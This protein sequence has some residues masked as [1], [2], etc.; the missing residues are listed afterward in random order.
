[1]LKNKRKIQSHKLNS[2]IAILS[3]L[4]IF[5]ITGIWA[6]LKDEEEASNVFTIGEVDIELIEKVSGTAGGNDEV[7]YNTVLESVTGTDGT[8]NTVTVDAFTEIEP[9]Q[10]IAKQPYVKNTGKNN[11]YVYMRVSV[12]L[13]EIAGTDTELFSYTTNSGW[14]LAGTSEEEIG[15]VT[16]NVYKYT[17][18][19]TLAPNGVTTTLFDS[20]T[21]T[22]SE[23]KSADYANFAEIQMMDI[24]AYAIQTEG[25]TLA[26]GYD[27]F[28]PIES[29]GDITVANYGQYVNLNTSILDLNNVTLEDSTHPASDWRVFS[30]DSNGGVWLIL[31]DYM[32]NSSFDVSTVGL[33]KGDGDYA[34]HGVYSNT[35]RATFLSGLA[36]NNWSNLITGSSV[37]G[38]TGVQVKGA[39]DINTW[40]DS[41][42]AN[43]GYTTLYTDTYS[44]QHSG[45]NMSDGLDGYYVGNSENP[46]TCWYDLRS[47][48]GYGNTLYFPH[49]DG[50]NKC[51]GYWLASP[52]AIGADNVVDVFCFC[53][54]YCGRYVNNDLGVRPAVYLPSNIQLDTS[55]AVW[56]IAN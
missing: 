46:T 36:H 56:T 24:K 3:V 5:L 44:N 37:A 33:E 4:L 20:V 31:A 2:I 21:V 50:V 28:F 32:P 53:N 9:G 40:K 49:Q 54:M 12:P 43:P 16:Y 17:Y 27:E 34:T 18:D 19:N 55:G 52:S 8:G 11:A 25:M 10:V 41:W 1:M 26:Q 29:V 23:W 38:A 7:L 48:G 42:N 35:D 47:D 6:V 45:N 22:S 51:Y 39:V 30:K 14:T 15:N 13:V